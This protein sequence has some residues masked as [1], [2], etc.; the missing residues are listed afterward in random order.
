MPSGGMVFDCIAAGRML[1]GILIV[2]AL[3]IES[4][5]GDETPPPAHAVNSCIG[6]ANSLKPPQDLH[7]RGGYR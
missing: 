3:L 2:P 1:A 5:S 6:P 4:R 7:A